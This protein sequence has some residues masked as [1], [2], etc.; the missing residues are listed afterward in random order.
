MHATTELLTTRAISVARTKKKN[1][2]PRENQ[3]RHCGRRK[4]GRLHK[5][6]ERYP[7]RPPVAGEAAT[8][9]SSLR[10]RDKWGGL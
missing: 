9:L 3:L 10:S 1:Y 5:K 4:R 7:R 6:E 8:S 2:E